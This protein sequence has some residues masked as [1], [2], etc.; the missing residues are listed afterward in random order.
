MDN[1][2]RQ[3]RFVREKKS[4]DVY[5]Y[6]LH[7]NSDYFIVVVLVYVDGL[8]SSYLIVF[9]CVLFLF[10]CPFMVINVSVQYN[11]G[12]LP[13]IILMT[14]CDNIGEPFKIPCTIKFLSLQPM[15]PPKPFD[16]SGGL[17]AFSFFLKNLNASRPSEHPTSGGNMSKCLGGMID[18]KCKTSS[19]H[20]NGFP[21]G[22]RTL[23]QYRR[24]THR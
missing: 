11:D 20:L 22:G 21:D 5:P 13:E 7:L 4:E 6:I 24:E 17:A 14:L 1:R 2:F 19:W 12:F 23:G 15:F 18:C 10:W 16:C 9:F 3:F 8:L